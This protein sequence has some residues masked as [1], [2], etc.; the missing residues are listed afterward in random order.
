MRAVRGWLFLFGLWV[1]LAPVLSTGQTARW[2]KG[3]LH[4]HSF[5]SDGDD[6]PEMIASWYKTN[7]YHFLALSDHNVLAAGEK[8]ITATNGT[9]REALAR[10]IETFGRR[11][12]TERRSVNGRQV[13]LKTLEEFRP[14]LEEPQRFLLVP[15]EEIS[16]DYQKLPI[17]INASNVRELI[18]PPKGTNVYDVIQQTVDI[19]LAQRQ[20]TGQPMIAHVN[21]PNFAWAL[22][23]EDIMRVRG[24]HFFEVYNGHPSVQNEGDE[25]RASV[26]RVW[27]IALA[28]RLSRLGLGPMFGLAVDDSH[29]YHVHSTNKSNPGRGWIM[30]RAQNLNTP[31]LI[32]AMENG[33]FYASTGVVLRD[34][35]RSPRGLHLEIVPEPGVTYVTTFI[36]TLRG[37]NP[38]RQPGR[39]PAKGNPMV[40]GIYSDEIGSVLGRTGGLTASYEFAGDELYVRAKVTSS[41]VKTNSYRQDDLEAAWVQPAILQSN[42]LWAALQPAPT[43]KAEK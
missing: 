22:T 6:F 10:Y 31:S 41:K 29:N 7:G 23:A 43:A 9:R 37:F 38:T 27:D 1:F 17:H 8:W 14:R 30:V 11:W 28:F 39:M 40:T 24:E 34:V 32:A 25:D 20:R 42:L 36:G 19:V 15:S 35:Q 5:W 2:W 3:N 4:T 21:H 13:R 33:D 18:K 16:A 12:V 26:E